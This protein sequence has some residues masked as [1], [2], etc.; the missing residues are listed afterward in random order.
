MNNGVTQRQ[1]FSML[2]K[3]KKVRRRGWEDDDYI[4]YV[5]TDDGIQLHTRWTAY[6]YNGG[7]IAKDI[8]FGLLVWDDW[9]VVDDRD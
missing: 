9:Q 2:M 8:L 4:Q 6:P 7:E 3:G 1:A 5:K